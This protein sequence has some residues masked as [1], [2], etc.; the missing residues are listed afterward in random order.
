MKNVFAFANQKGGVG[1]T[2]S[3]INLAASLAAMGK[4]VLLVDLDPQGN[5]TMGSGVNKNG[6]SFSI[7]DVLLGEASIRDALVRQP[8]YK[9]DVLAANSDLTESEISLIKVPQGEMKLK[10][11]LAEIKNEYDVVF[12]DC[13]P[14]LNMLTVNA[15]S[16]A[17]YVLIAMQC[18]Y[19]ALEGL[20]DLLNTVHQLKL[21]TNPELEIFG[22]VRTMF[23]PRSKLSNEVSKQIIKFFKQETFKTTIPRNIR[24]AESPSYGVPAIFYDRSSVGTLAYV[25]LAKEFAKRLFGTDEN[26]V[27]PELQSK[28]KSKASKKTE[29]TKVVSKK[30]SKKKVAKKSSKK[31]AKTTKKNSKKEASNKKKVVSKAN[32]KKVL[33]KAAKKV[34]KKIKTKTKLKSKPKTKSSSRTRVKELVLD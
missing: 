3:C 22:V 12:L 27:V 5:A 24:L 17:D 1:K 19:Y 11:A 30:E 20:S 33:K 15:L 2:T 9:H 14:S 16:A 7:N 26:I 21:A 34:T 18:E 29:A 25:K 4:K 32:K 8:E 10:E 31:I 6:V 28:A 13:P 23:D